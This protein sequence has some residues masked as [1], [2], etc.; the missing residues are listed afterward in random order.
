MD[1]VIAADCKRITVAARLPNAELRIGHLETGGDGS[2]AA[3]NAV[4]TEG[5]HIVRETA[6]ATDARNH[7]ELLLALAKRLRHCGQGTLQRC[8]NRV[9]AATGAPTHF[10]ITLE[11]LCSVIHIVTL[12]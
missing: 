8:Q 9:V 1:K 3:V 10:L 12:L 4:E 6:R 7:H 5:I 2:G 11:I